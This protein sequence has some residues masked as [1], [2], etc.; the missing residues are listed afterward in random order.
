MVLRH[1]RI[2][3]LPTRRGWAL[4]ATVAMMLVAS[5]N[6]SLTLGIGVAF[7]LAGLLA[8]ALLHTFRNLAGIEVTP[9]SAGE[10]FAGGHVVFT[11]A[12]HGGA[13]PRNA[14]TL[15][16]ADAHASGDVPAGAALTLNLEALAPTRGRRPLGRVTLSSVYPMGLWR[17]WAYVHFPLA[18]IVYPAVE[19]GAPPLPPG[20]SG[21]DALATGRR[22]EDAELAGLREFQRGDPPQRVAW[23]AVARGAGW[24]TKEFDGVGGGGPVTLAWN[25]L[26]ASLGNEA[27]L[28]RL[29]AWVMAAERAAR[30]FAL[31]VPGTNLPGAQGREHRRKR[32][33]GARAVSE[34]DG[35]VSLAASL[36]FRRRAPMPVARNRAPLTPAQIGWLGALLLSA[37]LPQAPHLP[38]W[39]AATGVL[40]V[41]VRL[42]VL[43]QDRQRPRAPPP[44]IPSWTL[45]LFAV[46][47]AFAVRGSF[48][49]LSG[50]DPSVAFLYI[51]VAI[52]FLETRTIRDGTLLVCLSCFLLITPF[53]YGQ[54]MLAAIAVLPAVVLVGATLDAMTEGNGI[55]GAAAGT[56]GGIAAQ[57]LH[58]PAGS[59][60][61]GPAVRAVPAARRPAMGTA[62]RSLRAD[63]AVRF[64]GARPDQRAV[65]VGRCRVPRGLR[66]AGAAAAGALLAWPGAVALR[67][68]RVDFRQ[69][70]VWR[71]AH[72]RRQG[73]GH[74]Y[75]HAGTVLPDLA[76]RARPAVRDAARRKRR[77]RLRH[78][79]A[80]GHSHPRS[81]AAGARAADAAAALRAAIDPP[82]VVSGQP[83]LRRA[84]QPGLPD[85]NPRTRQLAQEMRAQYPD[86]RQFVAAVLS[87]FN[88][89]NFVYTMS[90]PLLNEDTAD[91]FLF[92]TRRGFCEHYA[93]AFVVLLRAAG[94]PARVVTGY[95]GGTMNP[96]GGYMIVRQ[97]DAHA[98][99]E[100][101]I[102]GRWQ[103]YDPTAAVS[104]S[105]IESG[106]GGA[107][108][109]GERV[110]FLARLNESWLKTAELTWDALNHDW[111]RN[112]VG[113]NY[114]RQRSLWRE[115]QLDGLPPWQITVMAAAALFAWAGLLAAWLMFRRRRQE[116]ALVLWDELCRRLARAGLPRHGHEGP[117]AFA[118]RAAQ[119]W[120]QFAIAFAA[121]GQ[122]F[123]TLRYGDV[124]ASRQ[125][126]ALVATL[127]RAIEVLPASAALRQAA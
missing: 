72:P 83:A 60:H 121:I 88:R 87:W 107:L 99:A 66:R 82:S 11:L 45:V 126:D 55:A 51:L 10:T 63:R 109:A 112:I 91:E 5:L 46:A 97:S 90:P 19:I 4:I 94:I 74:L 106:L 84:C 22:S 8:S 52:K 28:S 24:F 32:V 36:G 103:R 98:W 14:V 118:Q 71:R 85:R 31:A 43:R 127:E 101:L 64:D 42:V 23:K 125:R 81:A 68:P 78:R 105:R 18:G 26:P 35:R 7:L 75:G 95:Q 76:V 124:A 102:D 92:D 16:A 96:R 34:G 21:Q 117:V 116:R 58:D 120:P 65:A 113:F 1:S 61:R 30:P 123:A 73:G 44:R 13:V 27:R 9:L 104:P 77:R 80:D 122:S 50:R 54:S 86:D 79:H 119:R 93:S 69:P 39:V 49:Y 62:V 115:W 29:T 6:Y 47:A 56:L 110:P 20:P 53:F 59:A 111:R 17:G 67:R 89:E 100:A 57:R 33:D 2:Y 114:Q 25:A 70:P 40:L 38:I 12:L 15:S 48:G 108:P 3:I 37:Q 41:V